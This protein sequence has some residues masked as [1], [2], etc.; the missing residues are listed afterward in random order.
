MRIRLTILAFALY[1]ALASTG[2]SATPAAHDSASIGLTTTSGLRDLGAAPP[3]MRID[4]TIVLP[5]RD[6]DGLKNLI[7]AQSNP[8]SPIFRRFLTA[9]QFIAYYAPSPADYAQ[10]IRLL[11]RHGFA[12]DRPYADRTMID[13]AAPVS[14]VQAA[15]STTIHRVLQPGKGYRYAA[16]GSATLPVDLQGTIMTVLGLNNLGIASAARP[17]MT[18]RPLLSSLNAAQSSPFV[19]PDQGF[20]IRAITTAYDYPVRHGFDGRGVRVGD[21]E[22]MRDVDDN[23]DGDVA[24]YLNAFGIKRTGPRTRNVVVNG[25]GNSCHA[26]NYELHALAALDTEQIVGAAPGVTLTLYAPPQSYLGSL[27]ALEQAIADNND[28]VSYSL[29]GSCELNDP[30]YDKALYNVAQHGTALGVT[31]VADSFHG[32]LACTTRNTSTIDEPADNPLFTAVGGTDLN[33]DAA[34]TYQS[35]TANGGSGGG[36][37]SIFPLPN[38]QLGVP[39]TLRGGRN[40]P[41]LVTAAS[42]NTLSASWYSAPYGCTPRPYECGWIGGIYSGPFIISDPIVGL[43]AEIDQV[44]GGRSGLLNAK[45]YGTL[46]KLGYRTKGGMTLFHDVTSGCDFP[47]NPPPFYCAHSGYD[48]LAGIGSP[49]GWNLAQALR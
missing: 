38:Y 39:G 3:A 16:V 4:L 29:Y 28:V 2:A 11:R 15:F 10:A 19:G 7:A 48:H 18:T 27:Y 26:P 32:N 49:E 5:Y 13:V 1:G 36:V 44:R 20:S 34:G 31:F 33:T 35:E 25:C 45:L 14:V 8:D 24:T 23:V 46:L 22:G 21:L 37:S 47:G 12:I 40:T 17:R 9:Q 43:I 42:V 6:A 41:D 30:A